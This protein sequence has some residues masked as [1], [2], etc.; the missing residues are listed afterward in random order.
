MSEVPLSL[1]YK[2]MSYILIDDEESGANMMLY[3][4]QDLAL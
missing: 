3:L 4:H 1:K 2:S